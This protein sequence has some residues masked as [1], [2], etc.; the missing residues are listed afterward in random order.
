[1]LISLP[2]DLVKNSETL[3]F[4]IPA[5][6]A[7]QV[8]LYMDR[9]RPRLVPGVN[10]SSFPW[11]ER[12]EAHRLAARSAR[13]HRLK[14]PGLKITRHLV[15]RIAARL[16][17]DR[18]SEQRGNHPRRAARLSR[19]REVTGSYDGLWFRQPPRPVAFR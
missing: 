4:E 13:P 14:S 10:V 1:M 11:R 17:L 9:F 18:H 19:A 2:N 12:A 8:R 5:T 6:V 7:G 16:F 3:E 15:R